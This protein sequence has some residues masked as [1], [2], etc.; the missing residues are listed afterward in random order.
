M[1]NTW[2]PRG[3]AISASLLVVDGVEMRR[4]GEQIGSPPAHISVELGR[5]F[6]TALVM[7]LIAPEDVFSLR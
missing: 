3:Q 4:I 5:L 6:T 1:S 7:S 2:C